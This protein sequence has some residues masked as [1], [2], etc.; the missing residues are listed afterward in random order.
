ML[1]PVVSPGQLGSLCI[2]AGAFF[3]APEF[4][5]IAVLMVPQSERVS[6]KCRFVYSCHSGNVF[7][8]PDSRS[9]CR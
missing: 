4:L 1:K 2:S 5:G 7:Q 6:S 8:S 9:L 3:A